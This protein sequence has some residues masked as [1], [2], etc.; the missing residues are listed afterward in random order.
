VTLA[1]Y[2]YNSFPQIFGGICVYIL[3]GIT[4]GFLYLIINIVNPD[5]FEGLRST[6]IGAQFLDLVYFSFVTLTTLGY[7]DFTPITPFPRTLSIMGQF[8]VAVLVAW[9]LG[10]YLSS[11]QEKKP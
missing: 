2:P 6:D 8:Y 4:W 9:L 1:P 10:M 7:R 5:S 3:L 11:K